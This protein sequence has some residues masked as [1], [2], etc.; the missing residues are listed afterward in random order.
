M[1]REFRPCFSFAAIA[2]V[3]LVLAFPFAAGVAQTSQDWD[4]TAAQ[5]MWGLMQV[6]GTVK[7]NFA[8]FDHVPDLDWDAAVRSSIPLVLAARDR[9]EYYLRLGELTALL[10]DG[11]TI[12][13][14][15]SLMNGDNDNPPVEFQAVERAILLV[16]TG[17]TDEIRA[18]E[19]KSGMELVAVGDVPARAY[20]EQN[21]LRYYPGSTTQNGEAF[22][23]FMLLNGPKGSTVGLTLKDVTGVLRT[24]TLTRNSRNRDGTT[25]KHRILDYSP[26]VEAKTP[27]T[28]IVYL[29][30]ASFGAEQLVQD[31][32][33]EL[34]KLDLDKL[35]GMIIDLRYNMGGDDS[36]AYPIV[37]RLVDRPV[38]GSTWST[39]EYL[40]AF[41]SWG[42]PER[43][44]QGDTVRIEPS[45]QKRYAG[46]LIVLTGPNTM[47]TSEDFL[48]P[49]D[50]SGRALLIGEATAG[51]TGNPVNAMLPG[52]AILRVCSKRDVYPD[53]REFVG[54]GIEP[55]IVVLPTVAGIRA[56]RD[57]VLEKAVEVLGDWKRYEAM[58]AYQRPQ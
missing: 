39:R 1:S 45:S 50:Y 2:C 11:H 27:R 4:N 12:V 53:G 42:L 54:V 33:A 30:L 43:S 15:P 51:T 41:A 17:D 52:G 47:S 44:Y 7:Y 56:N 22:G 48:V 38:V 16:R 35:T 34:D 40:P 46:P 29:R 8:Y 57:E 3:A 23:M 20:L 25:F 31:F 19:I 55:D 36:N 9:E 5:K 13:L 37:S 32:N 24:V 28:G 21:A 26:L 6:W 49:L 58:T 18:Q 14:S 10:R